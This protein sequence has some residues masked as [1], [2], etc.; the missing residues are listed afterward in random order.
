MNLKRR[1]EKMLKR[2]EKRLALQ[3][4]MIESGKHVEEFYIKLPLTLDLRLKKENHG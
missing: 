1:K 2:H 3:Q 4:V